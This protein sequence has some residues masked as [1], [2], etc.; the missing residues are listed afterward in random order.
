MLLG[1]GNTY[2]LQVVS[3]NSAGYFL[4]AKN[5]GNV[6]L[7]QK[8]S[9]TDLTVGV[10]IEVF[11]YLDRQGRVVATPQKPKAHI[12]E[13]ACLQ[14]VKTTVDGAFLNW[15][16]DKDLFVPSN[17]QIQPMQEGKKYF[18][19]V[20]R[21]KVDGR[22]IASAKID[23]FL[24]QDSNDELQIQQSVKLIIA[25]RTDLGYKAVV[26]HQY[27]GLLYHNE[28]FQRLRYGQVVQGYVKQI[29]ADG[30]IDLS[31]QGGAATR[32]QA[33]EKIIRYLQS[34]NGYVAVHD[35]SDPQLIAELFAMSKS[36]FKKT[37]GRLYKEKQIIIE[38][39]GIR[40]MSKTRE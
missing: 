29:R 2:T 37:I 20:F 25:D 32:D 28:V 16:L 26:N 31:L 15:G 19:Y 4:D 33:A 22:I 34:H 1:I 11:L 27:W 23:K 21:D 17:E 14:V 9:P 18:V 13:F 39:Q 36:N 38:A 8:L 3:C 30:K 24:S 7:P 12:G 6:L 5:L 35:K 10:D 40:L